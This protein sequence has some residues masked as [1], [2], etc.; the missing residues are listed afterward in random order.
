MVTK[1]LLSSLLKGVL[2]L[3]K[4]AVAQ[5]NAQGIFK[6]LMNSLVFKTLS[7]SEIK[8][9]VGF[10]CDC[11]SVKTGAVSGVIILLMNNISP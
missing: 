3:S 1:K 5:A 9:I 7:Q 11:T 4:H 8:N 10:S 2:F 6:A